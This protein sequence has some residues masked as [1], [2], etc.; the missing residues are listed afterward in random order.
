LNIDGRTVLLTGAS[1]GIGRAIAR[2]LHEEGASL[3]LSGRREEPL[4]EIC[5]ELG[6]RAEPVV[7]DLAEREGVQSLAGRARDA[8]IFVAGA[9]L[10]ASGPIDWFSAE[11]IGRAIHVNLEAPIQLSRALAPAM[12]E[13]GQGHIVLISSL[14]GR[15]TRPGAALYSATKFG[16][17]GFGLALRD[18]LH[19]TGVGVSNVLPGFVRDAGMYADTGVDFPPGTPTSTPRDVAAG[20]VRA[21]QTDEPEV[22]VAPRKLRIGAFIVSVAPGVGAKMMRRRNPPEHGEAVARAQAG[23]R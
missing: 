20:V 19:A 3:L 1:G 11:E 18:D 4:A 16:L 23:N 14:L 5:A 13:R 15:V 22:V 9:G 2:T 17:R 12:A 7:A 8:D 21:V 6:E 10:P